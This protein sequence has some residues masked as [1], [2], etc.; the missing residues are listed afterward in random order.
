L[1]FELVSQVRVIAQLIN[2]NFPGAARSIEAV[3]E[4]ARAQSGCSSVS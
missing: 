4:A 3:R 1:I 2:P